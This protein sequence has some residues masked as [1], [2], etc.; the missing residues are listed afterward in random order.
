MQS[1]HQTQKTNYQHVADINAISKTL[2]HLEENIEL[3]CGLTV[4]KFFFFRKTQKALTIKK[5][6]KL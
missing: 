5:I 2:T 1:S 4:S 6:D 3:F